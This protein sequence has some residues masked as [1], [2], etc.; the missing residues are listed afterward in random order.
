MN[1]RKVIFW[2]VTVA[3]GG[4]LFGLDTAVI[5]GCE[6]TIQKLWGLTDAMTGQMVAMALYGTIIGAIFGGIPAERVGRKQTLFWI[7]ILYLVSAAGS[8]LAPDVY[9]RMFFDLVGRL[10]VG[11]SSVVAPMYIP[12]LPP[13]D[14]RGHVTALFV[15]NIVLGILVP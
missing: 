6:R 13:T 2:S 3:L 1:H 9:T 15:L 7:A 11:A 4:F 12:E 10:S 14:T 8:A 5:S